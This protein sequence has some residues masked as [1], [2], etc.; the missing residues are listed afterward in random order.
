MG[1]D[2]WIG[3]SELHTWGMYRSTT[4]ASL[5]WADWGSPPEQLNQDPCVYIDT[6]G[7][8]HVTNCNATR[9]YMCQSRPGYGIYPLII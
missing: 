3:L 2:P 8:F 5:S 7:K 9:E 4:G 6:Y 1:S